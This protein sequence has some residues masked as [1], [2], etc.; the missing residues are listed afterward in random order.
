MIWGKHRNDRNGTQL[1]DA[2]QQHRLHLWNNQDTPASTGNSTFSDTS[3]DLTLAYN[4]NNDEWAAR[5]GTLGSDYHIIELRITH[6]NNSRQRI[7]TA[8]PTD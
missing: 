2:I 3:T 5:D 6:R 4:V 1:Y 8:R 7:E